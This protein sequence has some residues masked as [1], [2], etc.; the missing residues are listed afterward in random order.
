MHTYKHG[1]AAFLVTLCVSLAACTEVPSEVD[2]D[3]AVATAKAEQTIQDASHGAPAQPSQGTYL[4][5]TQAMEAGEDADVDL[6][7]IFNKSYNLMSPT[8]M[9]FGDVA[10][11]LQQNLGLTMYVEPEA[12]NE[13]G[14]V[15]VGGGQSLD[16]AHAAQGSADATG[17]SVGGGGAQIPKSGYKF[18]LLYTGTVKGLLDNITSRANVFW[19]WDAQQRRIDIYRQTIRHFEV[20]ALVG[21]YD[22]AQNVSNSSGTQ[23]GASS[24]GGSTST[25]VTGQS[26]SDENTAMK[27]ATIDV[28][29]SITADV[30]S[31]LSVDGV[32]SPGDSVGYLTVKDTPSRLLTVQKYVNQLN[33]RLSHMV[34][35]RV[36]VIDVSLDHTSNYGIDWNAVYTK[37]GSYGVSLVTNNIGGALSNTLTGTV[38]STGSRWSTSKAIVAAL[39]TQGDASIV[40]TETLST[41]S[42]MPAP[43]KVAKETTYLA[44]VSQTLATQGTTQ[45]TLTPGVVTA[46]TTMMILPFVENDGHVMMQLSMDISTLD[47]IDTVSSGGDTIQTPHLS[48][49]N[50]LERLNVQSGQTI[51][52]SGFQQAQDS[53]KYSGIGPGSGFW[54]WLGG[55][56]SKEHTKVTT[57]VLITP[58]IIQG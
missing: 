36:D 6:P 17:G 15:D 46:G 25:G 42:G 3:S 54:G 33:D 12:I 55:L 22:F 21:S 7:E 11:N 44:S 38:L 5:P 49:K 48:V 41:Q 32:I 39:N 28:W 53:N 10:A 4:G 23:A 2:Q 57:V 30:K 13:I 58:Y 19:H 26:Q 35:V 31:M 9:T 43:V 24:N 47:G 50:F 45:A 8:P 14:A 29:K 27:A 18:T 34:A 52:V 1:I 20:H 51:L 16:G 56:F 37:A 40:T